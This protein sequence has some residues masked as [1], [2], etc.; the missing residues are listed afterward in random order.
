MRLYE[1]WTE[2]SKQIG[3]YNKKQ[4]IQAVIYGLAVGDS[5]GVPFEFRLRDTYHVKDMVGYGT[6]NLP[7][8][9]WSDDTSL[10]LA[11]MEHLSEKSSISGLMDKFVKYRNGYLT[12]HNR[13][14]DI[15]IATNQAIDRYL[16]GSLP[17]ESG[18]MEERDNGN[19]ALMR[20]SPL[21]LLLRREFDFVKKVEC[22]ESYTKITHQHPR[23]IVGSILYIQI[24]IGL[25][26]NNSLSE[27]LRG[28]NSL[29]LDFLSKNEEYL[30][31]FEVNYQNI[32]DKDFFKTK[33]EQI[34]STGYVVDT[35]KAAIW[36]VGTTGSFEDAVLRAVNLGGDTD[37]I[38]A[39]TG[40]LA[41][42]LYKIESIPKRWINLLS[43]RE[44][45]DKKI[46]EFLTKVIAN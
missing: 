29:F 35:L 37:T 20:I 17:E 45:I 24:L 6:Y 22:I 9:T 13:C 46:E 31:E 41:G 2:D 1:K 40:T 32:F 16:G 39:I 30:K 7:A 3:F 12:P 18:G 11:L 42:A 5:L 14:F 23:A 10:T 25:L 33:R 21:A 8:G 44:L 28:A 38:G 43:N 34:F 26:L 4:Q 36:S 27:S 15:G 19:G